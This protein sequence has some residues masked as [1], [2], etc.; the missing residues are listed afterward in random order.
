M[1]SIGDTPTAAVRC[2]SPQPS[3]S[4]GQREL[5]PVVLRSGVGRPLFGFQIQTRNHQMVVAARRPIPTHENITR[6]RRNAIAVRR[7]A[8]P[9]RVIGAALA[10]EIESVL[11]KGKLGDLDLSVRR[12]GGGNV[13]S[14]GLE[15]SLQQTA[16][17]NQQ[18]PGKT[19]KICFIHEF[20]L[21][22]AR[23][24][25]ALSQLKLNG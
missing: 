24:V 6:N 20:R 25:R 11:I 10:R 23:P 3:G 15:R 2:D 14:F 1:P 19:G 5:W 17:H 7:D 21:F 12:L 22:V 18:S 13:L 8:R 9:K 4:P 16:R